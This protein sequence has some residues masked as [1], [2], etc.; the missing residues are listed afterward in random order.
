ML[1]VNLDQPEVAGVE[2]ILQELGV[3]LK[4][5][6]LLAQPQREA[7][8]AGRVA[9]A[10]QHVPNMDQRLL[11]QRAAGDHG[12]IVLL[13][14]GL[15]GLRD[16]DLVEATDQ[17]IVGR[18]DIGHSGGVAAAAQL[19]ERQAFIGPAQPGRVDLSSRQG[20]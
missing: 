1:S 18:R 9:N 20:R 4:L 17:V 10:E 14:L 6:G 11:G 19:A 12:L 8:L 5:I 15:G 16:I 7:D 3:A 13:S 2:G